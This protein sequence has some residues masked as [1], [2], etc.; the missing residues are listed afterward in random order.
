MAD[1]IATQVVGM[2]VPYLIQA[3][4]A[5]L[6]SVVPQ[7]LDAI[8]KQFKGDAYA[9]Q[10]LK[11]LEAKPE[12]KSRAG[13]LEM[14]LAEKMNAD[15]K[16]AALLEGYVKSAERP[17]SEVINQNI[18]LNGGSEVRGNITQIGKQEINR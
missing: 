7:V 6:E 1:T 9:K 18:T 4:K 14:I 2:I 17:T 12:D 13:A 5:T 15:R 11:R 3:G 8:R 10:T 16:F